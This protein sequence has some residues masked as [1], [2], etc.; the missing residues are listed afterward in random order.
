LAR[1][2]IFRIST[3]VSLTILSAA[4]ASSGLSA[5][6]AI[7]PGEVGDPLAS[8]GVL[9]AAVYIEGPSSEAAA[10]EQMLDHPMEAPGPWYSPLRVEWHKARLEAASGIGI[11]VLLVRDD[12][13][14]P[15][16]ECL[17]EALRELRAEQKG[18][19][20]IAPLARDASSTEAFLEA[21]PESFLAKLPTLEGGSAYLV[22]DADDR[23][24]AAPG[25]AL[26]TTRVVLAGDAFGDSVARVSSTLMGETP[27][28]RESDLKAVWREA[29]AQSP[30]AVLIEG[31]DDFRRAREILPSREY[32]VR[33]LDL[34]KLGI[35]QVRGGPQLSAS[36]PWWSVPGK[37]T[38]QAI[39]KIEV[40][41]TNRGI[42]GWTAADA[43]FLSCQWFKGGKLFYADCP[44]APIGSLVKPGETVAISLGLAASEADGTPF[45]EGDYELRIDLASNGEWFSEQGKSRP[46]SVPVHIGA[47]EK[48]AA[49]L[50]ESTLP[51]F[52]KT[53]GVYSVKVKV[54]NDGS[55]AWSK[56][57]GCAVG[58]HWLDLGA[59]GEGKMVA[60]QAGFAPIT[61]DVQPGQ[62][63]EARFVLRVRD[64]DGKAIPTTEGAEPRY[65]VAWDIFD[66][67]RWLTD[68]GAEVGMERVCIVSED[69]GAEFFDCNLPSALAAGAEFEA[70]VRIGN[71]GPR[72]WKADSD[73]VTC[74]WY[75][76]DGARAESWPSSE[77]IWRDVAVGDAFVQR[78]DVKTPSMPGRYIAEFTFGPAPGPGAL[79]TNGAD[80]VRR[81]IAIVG[82]RVEYVDLSA[83]ADVAAAAPASDP[84]S[85]NFDDEGG[86][87]P[88]ERFPPD[89]TESLALKSVYPTG[90]LTGDAPAGD[91]VSFSYLPAREGRPNAVVCRGQSIKVI[92]ARCDRLHIL[93]ASVDGEREADFEIDYRGGAGSVRLQVAPWTGDP[94]AGGRIGLASPYS[95]AGGKI[96]PQRAALFHYTA[97]LDA[98]KEISSITLPNDDKVRIVALTL[99]RAVER[100][101]GSE[102]GEEG[103][104]SP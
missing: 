30:S 7:A 85:G 21:V 12:I 59:T 44:A 25:G 89:V 10:G 87:F 34:T 103:A 74:T 56:A 57:A 15:V 40:G 42:K 22:W 78:L 71:R 67:A 27:V 37:V 32:G 76:L 23:P 8:S 93:C 62:T 90:Y 14:P 51:R 9:I 48:L 102:E 91:R 54:R 92:R 3:L 77:P 1:H 24:G 94:G 70:K 38:P 65:A 82:S 101:T 75:Y 58:F 43:I 4:V 100:Y 66:G 18:Y 31:W 53:D 98:T 55:E 41:A 96:R 11:D 60:K 79:V 72:D 69:T 64:G 83:Y 33:L 35:M 28:D 86:S 99:E 13:E 46:I 63:T 50:V 95:L 68:S 20:W 49:S 45:P 81:E 16:L 104:S 26:D 84:E 2:C 36:F 88:L 39:F 52:L 80:S 5:Q 17:I 61:A 97:D 47:T 29:A 73:V 19:P 6:V